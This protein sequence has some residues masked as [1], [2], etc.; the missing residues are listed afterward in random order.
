MNMGVLAI[1]AGAGMAYFQAGVLAVEMSIGTNFLLNE[2]WSFADHVRRHREGI[3][4][5][6]RF[7]KFNF[8]CAGGAVISLIMLWFLTEY[9]GLHYLLSNLVGITLATA[10]NYG[11]NA[12]L[13]WESARATRKQL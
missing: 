3:P 12:N 5:L 8:F 13:T 1:L 11:M 7:L 9:V 4:R 10:W 6:I 2:F